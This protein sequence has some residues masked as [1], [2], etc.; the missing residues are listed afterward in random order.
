[1]KPYP[2]SRRGILA[3]VA[4]VYDPLGFIS[5]FVL[6]GKKILQTL[7]VTGADWDD[8]I[9]EDLNVQWIRWLDGLSEL[10]K[11][12]INR[13]VKPQNFLVSAVQLHHFC[14]ASTTGYGC[15]SYLRLLDENGNIDTTANV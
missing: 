13:C 2:C 14:D 4:S 5:P 11:I 9:T 3:T 6:I 12:K 1:M 8:L 7:C 15:C 10:S